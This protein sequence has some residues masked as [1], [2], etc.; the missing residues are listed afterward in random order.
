M[1]EN[2]RHLN[3]ALLLLRQ[4][5]NTQKETAVTNPNLPLCCC[6]SAG[7]LPP[8]PAACIQHGLLAELKQ[9]GEVAAR[10]TQRKKLSEGGANQRLAHVEPWTEQT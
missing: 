2:H 10:A 1:S 4:R 3:D 6:C 7:L 9:T 8:W 5:A